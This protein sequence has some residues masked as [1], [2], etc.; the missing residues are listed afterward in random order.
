MLTVIAVVEVDVGRMRDLER[1]FH[2][3]RRFTEECLTNEGMAPRCAL[4]SCSPTSGRLSFILTGALR[5][6]TVGAHLVP[7]PHEHLVGIDALVKAV[8]PRLARARYHVVLGREDEITVS[9]GHDVLVRM[10]PQAVPGHDTVPHRPFV[11]HEL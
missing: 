5:N 11:R 8:A 1:S 6:D 2:R 4:P 7:Q 3:F 10:R 9:P